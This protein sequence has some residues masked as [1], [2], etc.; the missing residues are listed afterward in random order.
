MMETEYCRKYIKYYW[1]D[2]TQYGILTSITY[3]KHMNYYTIMKFH[4]K[5]SYHIIAFFAWPQQIEE[6]SKKEYL[7]GQIIDS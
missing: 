5:D 2:K 6:I 1:F 4:D 3:H 7:V